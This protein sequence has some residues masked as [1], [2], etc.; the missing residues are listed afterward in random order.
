MNSW[1]NL[2][3][4]FQAMASPCSLHIDGTD[5][6]LMR[7][8]AAAAIAEVRRIERKYSRYLDD[9]VIGRINRAAGG[10]AV[11]IDPETESL[12][13]FA[14]QLHALSDGLFDVTSGVLRR[15]WDFKN[16]RLAAQAELTELITMVGWQQVVRYDRHIR[17]PHEGMELDFGGFG[18]EYAADRAAATLREHGIAHALVNL[19]G[20][21]HAL[22]ER[23]LPELQGNAWQ[24]S[25]QHPRPEITQTGQPL[26]LLALKRGGLATSGD[27]ERFFLHEGRRYCHILDPR[28]GWPV[29][30]WQCVSVLSTNTTSAGA[31]ATIAMI[32]GELGLAWLEGQGASYLAV[33]P[34]GQLRQSVAASK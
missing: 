34:D 14:A 12:L 6:G 1:R 7:R 26:A 23:G 19:G 18:K 17:L 3:F 5:E 32:K 20:D 24:V 13:D 10:A 27:Y 28:T 9:S 2:C 22:G 29:A 11:A 25:I 21:L 33:Q 4:E 31:L 8:A 16:G 15:A 30:H